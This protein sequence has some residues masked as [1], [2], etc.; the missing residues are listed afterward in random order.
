MLFGVPQWSRISPSSRSPP[1]S[2]SFST[3]RQFPPRLQTLYDNFSI[4]NKGTAIAA[5][6]SHVAEREGGAT[7]HF[8]GDQKPLDADFIV[9]SPPNKQASSFAE[10]LGLEIDESGDIVTKIPFG[11]TNLPGGFATGDAAVMVK[12]IL[13]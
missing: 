2:P 12:A 3:G 10:Q 1:I 7:I 8:A 11:T 13:Q 4:D 9:L 6:I 5:P